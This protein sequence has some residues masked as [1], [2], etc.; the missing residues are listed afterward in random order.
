MVGMYLGAVCVGDSGTFSSVLS[1]R[2]KIGRGEDGIQG[3]RRG[4][5]GEEFSDGELR[6]KKRKC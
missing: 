2:R 1:D 4:L 6:L 3:G 5:L